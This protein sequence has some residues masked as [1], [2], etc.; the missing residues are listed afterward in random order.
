MKKLIF[1]FICLFVS[2]ISNAEF[3]DHV[4]V[5]LTKLTVFPEKFEAKVIIASGVLVVKTGEPPILHFSYDTFRSN[6]PDH[7]VLNSFPSEVESKALEHCNDG[8]YASVIGKF[9]YSKYNSPMDFIGFMDSVKKIVF[10]EK[11]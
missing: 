4:Q 11:K 1:S 2:F 8:C 9:E 7:I 5:S 6:T 3:I 10:W